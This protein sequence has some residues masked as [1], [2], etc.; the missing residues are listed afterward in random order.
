[1]NAKKCCYTIFSGGRKSGMR[2]DIRINDDPIPY[3]PN[4]IFLGV[5]FDEQLCFNAH[6]ANL[7]T[8]ALK[9]LNIIKQ[10]SHSSWRMDIDTLI[11]IYRALI[12]SVFDYSFF[13]VTSPSDTS[14]G[15]VQ[16]VQNR[17][18]RCIFRLEWDS[19]THEL[20][21]IS[22][23]IPIRERLIQ[24]GSRYLLKCLVHKNPLIQILLSEYYYSRNSL[25]A[26]NER[27]K[28][29]LYNLFGR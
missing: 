21:S 27:Q 29:L 9:C 10:F 13:S 19:P 15:L 25:L 11:N 14:L 24:L 23:I 26:K 22:G 16:R 18:I 5:T 7:R 20:P 12:S 1:M 2:L 6:Y 8:R 4:P 3:N 17:A 28:M